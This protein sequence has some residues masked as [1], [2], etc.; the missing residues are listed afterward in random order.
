MLQIQDSGSGIP[1]AIRGNLHSRYQRQPGIEDGRFGIGL[2]MVLIR[3]A[4]TIHGGTVLVDQP[5]GGGTRI[6]MTI[7]IRSNSSGNLRSN[8]LRVDYSG[9]RDHGLMELSETL[10][11]FLYE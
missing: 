8:V 11:A 4:A 3:S 7:A 9:E 5:Q 2:G 1:D 6:T 10:P